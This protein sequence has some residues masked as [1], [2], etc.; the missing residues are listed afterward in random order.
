MTKIKKTNRLLSLPVWLHFIM[1]QRGGAGRYL[2]LPYVAACGR[3]WMVKSDL[4]NAKQFDEIKRL[5]VQAVQKMLGFE[6]RHS[7]W[8]PYEYCDKVKQL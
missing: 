7:R 8:T 2:K 1:R 5:S 4:I 6:L 3:S